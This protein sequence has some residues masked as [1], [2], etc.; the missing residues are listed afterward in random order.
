MLTSGFCRAGTLAPA[1]AFGARPALE[2]L[3]RE[4]GLEVR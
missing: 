2:R 1:Q 3:S 4:A